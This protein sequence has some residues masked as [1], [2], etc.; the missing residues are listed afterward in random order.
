[1]KSPFAK[2][3]MAK[4]DSGELLAKCVWLV[5]N[6]ATSIYTRLWCVLELKIAI[7]LGLPIVFSLSS[8]SR[9]Q[10]GG[11][12]PIPK[13]T[14]NPL[15]AMRLNGVDL[16]SYNVPDQLLLGFDGVQH[17]ECS[18]P[19]DAKLIREVVQGSEGQLDALIERISFANTYAMAR[20]KHEIKEK[21]GEE[22]IKTL[23][24]GILV[25]ESRNLP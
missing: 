19:D 3:L 14:R 11:D 22:A 23:L 1:M 24:K 9:M 16:G 7:E 10:G 21:L 2:A 6:R 25:I 8:A 5:S 15:Q 20:N 17:A 4:N 18:D 12:K 13:L